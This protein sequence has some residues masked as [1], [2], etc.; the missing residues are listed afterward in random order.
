MASASERAVL[1]SELRLELALSAGKLGSW[2]LT[3]PDRTLSA[4]AQCKANHGLPPDAVLTIDS[5]ADAVAPSHRT[6]F[7]TTVEDA[8]ATGGAFEIEI[9]NRWPDGTDHWL[10]LCGKMIDP[11][12]MLGVSQDVTERHRAEE[13]L[14]EADRRKDDFLAVLGHELRNPLSSIMA[15]T[16]LLQIKGPPD[17]ALARARDAIM[18]QAHQ[19]TRLV[20]DLLDVGRITAGKLRL[21]RRR[22]ELGEI[23]VH[24]VDSCMP[25]IEK[26]NHRIVVSRPEEPVYL[27]ADAAR[28]TQTLCNLIGNAAKYMHDGGTIRVTAA[29]VDGEAVVSVRDGGIGIA[30]D[31]LG[32]IFQ[33]FVQLET[34]HDR[35][36]GG[37]GIG[38]SL[39]KSIVEMHG[40]TVE[41]H[42]AG[43]G[44]GSEFVVRLP[45]AG[46]NAERHVPEH[47]PH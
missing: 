8:I 47:L 11:R 15:A 27:D 36:E 46:A 4:S 33:R 1:I 22:V 41:A 5:V 34:G 42:S 12:C 20:D 23:L 30:P 39:V 10:L 21:D 13:A 2:Q 16:R 40:G 14:R 29:A 37:L 19:L 7:S 45:L 32:K 31:L 28:L 17:P 3:L 35:T 6:S 38:L 43:I 44:K 24:A 18:R 26:H 25:V 9:P